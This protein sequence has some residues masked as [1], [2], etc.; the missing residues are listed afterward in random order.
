MNKLNLGQ[1]FQYGLIRSKKTKLIKV[2]GFFFVSD[3]WTCTRYNLNDLFNAR[4]HLK[5]NKI[6]N[7]QFK[8][9]C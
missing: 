7:K 3:F 6:I 1:V 8:R 5:L 4:L 9:G 2:N